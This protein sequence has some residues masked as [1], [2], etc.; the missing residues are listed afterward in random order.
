MEIEVNDLM[1][2]FRRHRDHQF[3][4]ICL[5]SEF[6]LTFPGVDDALVAVGR[7]AALT[8]FLGRCA[9]CGRHTRVTGLDRRS[10][11]SPENQVLRFVLDHVG[12]FFCHVCIARRL[13]LNI[14]T[15]QEAVR[16][17][18]ASPDVCID[19]MACSGCRRHRRVLGRVAGLDQ[20]S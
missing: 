16:H 18:R 8:E 7:T 4:S 10:A 15:L 2:F 6:R 3:C 1:A 5:A 19:D 17:L 13:Q 20:V 9:V 12:R 11:C 14:G